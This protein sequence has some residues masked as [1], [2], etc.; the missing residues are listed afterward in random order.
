M[1]P[2]CGG[3]WE[4]TAVVCRNVGCGSILSDPP[5]TID[6]DLGTEASRDEPEIA[7]T[8][9]EEPEVSR[10]LP[11]PTPRVVDRSDGV[12][13]TARIV[14][15]VGGRG[16]RRIELAE[17]QVLGRLAPGDEQTPDVDVGE[18]PELNT[19]S[20]RHAQLIEDAGGWFVRNLSE[21]NFIM[22]DGQVLWHVG[23]EAPLKNGSVLCLSNVQFR[24]VIGGT[25]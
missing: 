22:V 12:A 18:V 15:E 11:A 5:V 4:S 16:G 21:S 10:S 14:L 9:P 13:P 7:G 2:N 17:G 23:D 3:E 1:C 20:R 8:A 24:V 25:L 19:V 6:D